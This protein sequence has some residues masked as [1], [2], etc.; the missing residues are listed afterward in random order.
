MSIVDI[1][2]FISSRRRHTRCALVTGVQTCALP[3]SACGAA[4]LSV[5]GRASLRRR[6][7]GTFRLRRSGGGIRGPTRD[8]GTEARLGGRTRADEATTYH[9]VYDAMLI[10]MIAS[11]IAAAVL[12][13]FP[14]ALF[15]NSSV[16][17]M[18]RLLPLII[19]AVA[20][21]DVALAACAYR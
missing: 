9:V 20:G 6:N 11:V 3:I 13:A 5:R 7:P 16:N 4:A 10:T 18:D 12:F 17:G 19:L 15:P 14:Q 21:S 1:L 2:F 8:A